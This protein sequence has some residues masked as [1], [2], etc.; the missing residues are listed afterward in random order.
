MFCKQWFSVEGG[1]NCKRCKLIG[2]LK[3]RLS[4][5]NSCFLIYVCSLD[6]AVELKKL[7]N[8]ALQTQDCL[9]VYPETFVR[10]LPSNLV[11]ISYIANYS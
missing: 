7:C 4:E 10:H 9:P 5:G 8:Y 6:V 2:D 11:V 1:G 3:F